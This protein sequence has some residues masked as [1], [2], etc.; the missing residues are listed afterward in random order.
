MFVHCLD[1]VFDSGI[2]ALVNEGVIKCLCVGS[3]DGDNLLSQT[4]V[5]IMFSELGMEADME[6]A[7]NEMDTNRDQQVIPQA[8]ACA[9]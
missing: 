5:R 4:E 2:S 8:H 1:F 7:L 6:T 9:E 3:T